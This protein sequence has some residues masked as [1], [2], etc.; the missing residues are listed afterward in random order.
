MPVAT[1]GYRIAHTGVRA[2]SRTL[3]DAQLARVDTRLEEG[4]HPG[5]LTRGGML[6]R[7]RGQLALDGRPNHTASP[8]RDDRNHW[9]LEHKRGMHEGLLDLF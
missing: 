6:R 1:I 8:N 3:A 2:G 7:A 5:P 9:I 4:G